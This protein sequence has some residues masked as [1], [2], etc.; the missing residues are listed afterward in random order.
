MHGTPAG[1]QRNSAETTTITDFDVGKSR[2]PI[3]RY[4]QP[5]LA[6][7]YRCSER[8]MRR[9]VISLNVGKIMGHFYTSDQVKAI[10]EKLGTP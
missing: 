7:L 9:W 3:R 5:E 8:T 10:V 6:R 2:F 4:T 1:L